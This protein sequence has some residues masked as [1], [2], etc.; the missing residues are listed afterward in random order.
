MRNPERIK[1]L[2]NLIEDFWTKNPDLRLVQIISLITK[3]DTAPFY[4]EDEIL[5]DNLKQEIKKYE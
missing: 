3:N 4:I 1:E 2:L 5:I